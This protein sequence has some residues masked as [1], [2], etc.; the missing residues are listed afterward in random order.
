MTVSVGVSWDAL[1]DDAMAVYTRVYEVVGEE[2]TLMAE[3]P[4][5]TLAVNFPA[6]DGAHS[7]VLR[8]VDAEDNESESSP[9]FVLSGTEEETEGFVWSA[10]GCIFSVPT[11]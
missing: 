8:T 10:T 6:A 7:Y 3:V 1:P 5:A 4:A 2:Y 9:A 11:P